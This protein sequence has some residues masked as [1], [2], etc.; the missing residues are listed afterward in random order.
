MK[1]GQNLL[2][3]VKQVLPFFFTE[4]LTVSNVVSFTV[5][6]PELKSRQGVFGSPLFIHTDMDVSESASI[7][8][9]DYISMATS[10]AGS[11]IRTLADRDVYDTLLFTD[12]DAKNR[13]ESNVADPYG[14]DKLYTKEFTSGDAE[15]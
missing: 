9:V 5:E 15:D 13:F 7:G 6:T 12:E 1:K 8:S 2:L 10:I 14:Q 3:E 11:G 4:K